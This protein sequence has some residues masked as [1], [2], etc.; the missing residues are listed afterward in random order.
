MQDIL[1]I[2]NTFS[3]ISLAEMDRVKLMNRIDTKFAFRIG[4]L[5]ELLHELK[6]E[7]KILEISD[8]LLIHRK[9]LIAI[10]FFDDNYDIKNFSKSSQG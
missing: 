5:E 8:K 6:S 7:Y 2:L 4:L 10:Y 9:K 3:P 1:N